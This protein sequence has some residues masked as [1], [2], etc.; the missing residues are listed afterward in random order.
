[1]QKVAILKIIFPCSHNNLYVDICNSTSCKV[2]KNSILKFIK[3][4][5]NQVSDIYHT[6]GLKLLTMRFGLSHL[7]DHKFR[8]K[9][10]SCLEPICSCGQ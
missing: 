10:Q 2:F 7:A 1:M 5:F 8:Q 6:E 9:F 3:S 4:E